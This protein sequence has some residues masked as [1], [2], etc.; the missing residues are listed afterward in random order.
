MDCSCERLPHG[1]RRPAHITHETIALGVQRVAALAP[2]YLPF[3]RQRQ[4]DAE[5][6]RMVEADE[7]ELRHIR[8]TTIQ[9]LMEAEYNRILRIDPPRVREYSQHRRQ[10]HGDATD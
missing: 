3:L 9:S 1:L 10:H 2:R 6:L 8:T 7:Q 5:I 4:P